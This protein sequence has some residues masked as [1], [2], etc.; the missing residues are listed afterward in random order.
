MTATSERTHDPIHRVAMA[1]ERESEERLVV[2]TWLDPDGHLPE[3][4]HPTLEEHWE[5]VEGTARVKLDGTWHELTP[6]DGAVVVK[7]G[8]RHELRNDSG[9]PARLRTLVL[10]AGRLEEFLRESAQAA[11][12]GLYDERNLPTGL[13]GA[14]WLSDFALRFR[15]ETV[16]CS[17]PPA[18]QRVVLPVAA[19]LTRRFRR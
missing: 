18:L 14:A 5:V 1:F 6:A 19:R 15:D 3:H 9:E 11:Q 2:H 12:D 4:F 17:P 13:R 10:P 8:M 7:R 16:V